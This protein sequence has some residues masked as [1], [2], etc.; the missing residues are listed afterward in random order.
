MSLNKAEILEWAQKHDRKNVWD[1]RVTAIL[2]N[3]LTDYS[4]F[5]NAWDLID[6]TILL[7]TSISR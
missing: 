1:E 3:P 2:D 6:R 5:L 7:T 4:Q